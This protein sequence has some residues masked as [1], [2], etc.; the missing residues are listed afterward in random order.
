MRRYDGLPTERARV[1]LSA[2]QFVGILQR[3][4]GGDERNQRARFQ[5]FCGTKVLYSQ[6]NSSPWRELR[7]ELDACICALIWHMH[8][9]P[10]AS[11][12]QLWRVAQWRVRKKILVLRAVAGPVAAAVHPAAA[13]AGAAAPLEVAAVEWAAAAR[14]VVVVTKAAAVKVVA[15]A[16]AQVVAAEARVVEGKAAGAVVDVPAAVVDKVVAEAAAAGREAVD[17]PVEVAAP[18]VAVEWE[19]AVPPAVAVV[20]ALAVVGEAGEV[21]NLS[22]SCGAARDCA[23]PLFY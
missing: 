13:V 4:R 18:P 11:Y 17:L 14:A 10:R 3:A 20:D 7:S 23:A 1:F 12:K 6:G 5:S 15:A 22:H 9:F 19:E 16:D 8:C 21:V 2:G